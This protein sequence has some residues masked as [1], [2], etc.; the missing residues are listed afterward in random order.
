QKFSALVR[1]PLSPRQRMLRHF[2]NLPRRTRARPPPPHPPPPRPLHPNRQPLL[3]P[4]KTPRHPAPALC[5]SNQ[6]PATSNSLLSACCSFLH[7]PIQ[8]LHKTQSLR[9]QP[10]IR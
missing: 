8:P 4:K 9:T 1:Q 6:Q 3:G 5:T 7:H 2:P 10:A